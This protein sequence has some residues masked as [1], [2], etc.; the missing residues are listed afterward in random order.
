MTDI[1]LAPGASVPAR[2]LTRH[3]F[4]GGATGTGKTTTAA[5]IVDRLSCPVI[6]LDAKGDLEQAG[7]LHVPR[8]SLHDMG[9][10]LIARALDLSDAQSGTLHMLAAWSR[11]RIDSLQ[12]MRRALGDMVSDRD[13]ITASLG[14][15]TPQ[16]IAAIQRALVRLESRAPWL[17]GPGAPDW[18]ALAGINTIACRH[19]AHEP[20]IYGAFAAHVLAQLYDSLPEIG[21][22]GEPRIALMIDEAHLLFDGAPP[23]VARQI[24]RVTRLIRSR[25]VALIYVTQSPADLPDSILAQLGTRIQH[26]LRATTPGQVRALRATAQTYDA[27]PETIQRLGIG[28]ALIS[29][30]GAPGKS[31][32]IAAGRLPMGTVDHDPAASYPVDELA[33]AIE[34]DAVPA[35]APRGRVA[36]AWQW[37]RAL[38]WYAQA[39]SIWAL[40]MAPEIFR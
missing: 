5:A 29:V 40:I 32:Q 24:E 27:A 38:P 9:P 23:A 4:I 19:I 3:I 12:D 34:P 37:W 31:V 11:Q 13:A 21:D 28:Q 6:I 22:I 35:A 36:R 7:T 14:L 16:S 8:V 26:A 25:G 15:V 30:A 2:Q 17:F 18:R 20:G 10:D 33:T 39:A 1:R